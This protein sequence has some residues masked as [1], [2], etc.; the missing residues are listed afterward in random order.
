MRFTK[1]NILT[2]T[3][4][5]SV[6]SCKT[7]NTNIEFTIMNPFG[8]IHKFQII[9]NKNVLL[10]VSG[11][12]YN[13]STNEEMEY[14]IKTS[15]F[16]ILNKENIYEIEKIAELLKNSKLIE[17]GKPKDAFNYII[18]LNKEMKLNTFSTK[19]MIPIKLRDIMISEMPFK[20][21]YYCESYIDG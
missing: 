8:C 14:I 12:E 17:S 6:S 10:S 18:F 2:F 11:L 21:D 13:T 19:S 3:I 4:I 9:D 20:I 7:K 15:E 5:L 16:N 1:L